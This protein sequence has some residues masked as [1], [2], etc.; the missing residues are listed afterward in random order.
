MAV[1]IRP[2]AVA[3]T[4]MQADPALLAQEVDHYL[5]ASAPAEAPGPCPK[6]L[7]APHAGHIYSGR[8][9]GRAYAL[10]RPFGQLGNGRIR[11]VVLLGPAHRVYVQGIALPGVDAYATPLGQ[12]PIATLGALAVADLPFVVTRPDVH[13]PE[14]SLEVHVPFLQR[15]LGQFELL[16]LVVGDAS[17]DQVA[18]VIDR[19]W[20]GDDVLMVISTDLS[21]F[22]SYDAAN[23]I[24]A[25][26]CAQV[27][28]LDGRL[29]HQQ[30]CG[31]TPVNGLLALA[32]QRSMRIEQIER[33]NSGDTGA[34]TPQG[35]ERVVGYASFAL[36]EEAVLRVADGQSAVTEGVSAEQGARLVRLAR[37]ALNGAVGAPAGGDESVADLQQPG[38]AFVT[39]TQ[40]GQ[41]RGC[42]GSLLAHRS[43]AEDVRDN[44]V[45]AALHDPRFAPVSAQDAPALRV[46]VS[47]LT[48]AQPLQFANQAHA[49]WQLQ[50]GVDGVVLECAHQGR[51]H[52]STY[53]PQ[54]WEQL[55]SVIAFM[56]HLKAKAG[57][58][59]DFW[60]PQVKLSVYR[61]QKFLE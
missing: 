20:G 36:Y 22:H 48:P 42:I 26:S 37:A 1:T 33:C 4:F 49:L 55:P 29:D 54:V 50:P 35:R 9:A 44:A 58:P 18:Q 6:V 51:V 47:V 23:A 14:H 31:A 43:L 5:H 19:L 32:R 15:A 12:V 8:T 34:N 59:Q 52:R 46:E 10:I 3:G 61:V 38:A 17:P 56:A 30:A 13:G 25:A 41:L 60:S 27:L 16:P 53:L 45:A 39:L 28:A 11:R 7:I 57:L 21:H 2:P 24:D 40:A